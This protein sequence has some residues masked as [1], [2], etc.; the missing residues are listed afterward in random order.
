MSRIINRPGVYLYKNI[1]LQLLKVHQCVIS[2]SQ[3]TYLVFALDMINLHIAIIIIN[4][5]AQSG[6]D[7]LLGDVTFHLSQAGTF[8]N[9]MTLKQCIC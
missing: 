5:S 3:R 1:P 6:L 4:N 7:V 2:V 8:C 9:I